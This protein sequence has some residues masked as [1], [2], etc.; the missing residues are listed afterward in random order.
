MVI[1]NH[2]FIVS[3]CVFIVLNLIENLLHYNI[4]RHSDSELVLNSP[5]KKDWIRI[6]IVMIIF[7][8]L[9][10]VFTYYFNTKWS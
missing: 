9:Q 7:A 6:I 10:G 3:F 4:G 5:T 1:Q 2:V 8:I